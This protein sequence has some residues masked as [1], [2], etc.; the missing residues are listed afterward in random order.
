M[1]ILLN[2]ND[3]QAAVSARVQELVTINDDQSLHVELLDDGTAVVTILSPGEEA[4]DNH[5]SNGE[6]QADGSPKPRKTRRTKAQI[7]ADK[8]A[9]EE[10]RKQAAQDAAAEQDAGNVAPTPTS[11]AEPVKP[12]EPAPAEDAGETS[13]SPEQDAADLPVDP[14]P[15]EPAVVVEEEQAQEAEPAADPEPVE[16][17][18][19]Q[20]VEQ[21][22]KQSLFANLRKPNNQ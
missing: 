17:K 22:K 5:E 16:E 8:K 19:E 20:P 2:Q 7:E 9:E 13:Q 3:I 14:Q 6:T 11:S 1:Q 12:T 18:A 10:A 4:G 15:T 21:P